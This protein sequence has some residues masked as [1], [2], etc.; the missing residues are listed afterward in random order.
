[1]KRSKHLIEKRTACVAAATVLCIAIG[2]ADVTFGYQYDAAGNRVRKEVV[3]QPRGPVVEPAP[4][5]RVFPSITTGQ[6]TIENLGDAPW[7]NA[8]YRVTNAQGNTVASGLLS[9]MSQQ[10]FV[11]VP[12]GIYVLYVVDRENVSSFKIIKL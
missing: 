12:G 9:G 7:N 8:E 4:T 10:V 11:N 3:Q 1:M 6:I 5:A 2:L